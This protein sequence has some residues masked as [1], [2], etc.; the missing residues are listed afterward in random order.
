MPLALIAPEVWSAAHEVR[1]PGG[2]RLPARMT[3]IRL[4]SRELLVHSPIPADGALAAE[5]AALGPVAH[6]VAPCLLHHLFVAGWRE[7]HPAA[8]FHAAPGLADKRPDLRFDET[9]SEQAP[10]AWRGVVDQLVV[11]GQPRLN[12]V[13]FLHRP[14][15]TLLVSDLVFNVA[16]PRPLATELVLRL[17]GT[18]RGLAMSRLWRRFTRDRAAARASIETIVGWDFDRLVMGHGEPVLQGA[19]PAFTAAVAWALAGR[20]APRAA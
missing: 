15:R 1:L 9:L 13:V 10:L 8:R 12:E 19:R 16:R 2:V 3:V 11:R 18:H 4:P 17:M 5:I 7:R 20:A 14:T 6:V